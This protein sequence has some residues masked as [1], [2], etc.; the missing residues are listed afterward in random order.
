MNKKVNH[1]RSFLFLFALSVCF[2]FLMAAGT[3][4]LCRS[5]IHKRLPFYPNAELVK[6]EKDLVRYR[7]AGNTMMVFYTSDDSETVAAWYRALNLEQLEK[8]IFRGLADIQRRH[9]SDPAG[10]TRIYYRTA[11]AV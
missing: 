10:G 8:G 9:E 11:C 1:L 2:V 5:D 7:A 6:Q 3:D 4:Q